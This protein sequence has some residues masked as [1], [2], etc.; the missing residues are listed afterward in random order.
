MTL[1]WSE[2]LRRGSCR[3][4]A[5]MPEAEMTS[6]FSP[7]CSSRRGLVQSR[8][9][10]RL[11]E[12]SYAHRRRRLHPRRRPRGAAQA[13]TPPAAAAAPAA[14]GQ[15]V[16]GARSASAGRAARGAAGRAAASPCPP[17]ATA[18]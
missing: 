12:S 4:P 1:G 10:A 2:P 18:P 8:R 13:Q 17:P 15:A 5:E 7:A 14:A 11:T 9:N 16:A 6:R 3:R